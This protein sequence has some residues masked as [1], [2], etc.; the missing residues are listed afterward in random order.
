M[1]KNVKKAFLGSGKYVEKS[2]V[3]PGFRRSFSTTKWKK[4]GK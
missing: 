2:M 4:P 1:L 3:Y